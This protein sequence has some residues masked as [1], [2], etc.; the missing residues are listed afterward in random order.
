MAL[1]RGEYNVPKGY[2]DKYYENVTKHVQSVKG[3]LHNRKYTD[4]SR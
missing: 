2:Y 3:N 4:Y 1:T